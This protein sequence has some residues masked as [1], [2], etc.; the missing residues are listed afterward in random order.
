[1]KRIL[2]K[3]GQMQKKNKDNKSKEDLQQDSHD[4]HNRK[5]SYKRDNKSKRKN[6]QPKKKKDEVHS[7][8]DDYEV[9]FSQPK[10]KEDKKEKAVILIQALF[11]GYLAREQYIDLLQ[12]KIEEPPLSRLPAVTSAPLLVVRKARGPTRRPPKNGKP[13]QVKTLEQPTERPSIVRAGMASS[14]SNDAISSNKPVTVPARI[15]MGP[16]GGMGI[17]FNPAEALAK[18]KATP[19]GTGMKNEGKANQSYQPS[20]PVKTRSSS[21]NPTKFDST[22]QPGNA[23]VRLPGFSYVPD[24]SKTNPTTNAS[25]TPEQEKPPEPKLPSPKASPTKPAPPTKKRKRCSIM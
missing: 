10:P 18:L 4:E 21:G 1:L 16:P 22:P 23:K 5:D 20:S 11:R 9:D 15:R 7:E 14:A 24:S 13:P 19:Q 12:D 25:P 3:G 2:R 17:A 6:S 8:D